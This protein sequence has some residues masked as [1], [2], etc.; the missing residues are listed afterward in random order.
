[1]P[2][3]MC[4]TCG[5]CVEATEPLD[6]CPHCKEKCTFRD[7]TCYRPECGGERNVDPLLTAEICRSVGPH[8][9]IDYPKRNV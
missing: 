6:E 3:W 9:K 8:I 7:V 2:Y 5:T 4:S 1:M